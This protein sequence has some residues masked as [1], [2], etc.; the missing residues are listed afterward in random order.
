MR[1]YFAKT[2]YLLLAELLGIQEPPQVP[3]H[4]FALFVADAGRLQDLLE[5][6]RQASVGIHGLLQIRDVIFVH[7]A[8]FIKRERWIYIRSRA[9]GRAT[10]EVSRPW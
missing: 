5:T 8:Q 9:G 4:L 3:F 1:V 10:I 2:F 7:D 6:R